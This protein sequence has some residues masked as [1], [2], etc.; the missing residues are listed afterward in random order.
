MK[1]ITLYNDLGQVMG[2]AT[3][4]EPAAFADGFGDLDAIEGSFNNDYYIDNGQAHL[5]D[6]DPSNGET[7]YQF[8]YTTKSWSV[9]LESTA[10]YQRNIR[11]Q[12]FEPIDQ[13]NPVWYASLSADEQN[14][15]AAYRQ[16][17][18]DVP[19]QSGFPTDIEWPAKPAW[20]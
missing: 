4:N 7:K 11:T 16:Q 12:L 14:Q 9:D 2:V 5:K 10:R 19:Q 15:L 20:L 18:L 6:P 3:S 13:I 1:T 17:L 8:D